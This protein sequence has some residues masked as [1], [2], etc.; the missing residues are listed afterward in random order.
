M[1]WE[2]IHPYLFP[3]FATLFCVWISLSLMTHMWVEHRRDSVLKKL[4]W[5]FILCVPFIGWLFYCGM[6]TPLPENGVRAVVNADVMGGGG[7]S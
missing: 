3:A 2:A 5:S 6:Y 1:S 4:A 7:S